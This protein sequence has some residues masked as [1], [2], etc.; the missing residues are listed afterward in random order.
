MQPGVFEIPD[1]EVTHLLLHETGYLYHEMAASRGQD[2][3]S[4]AI[5]AYRWE[6][7]CT[8][9]ATD[10]PNIVDGNGEGRQRK[11]TPAAENAAHD[12]TQPKDK[13]LK[14]NDTCQRGR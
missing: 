12:G 1:K 4:R 13:A 8:D 3:K 10:Q 7:Q 6:N 2:A 5:D 14:Q 9:Q 11:L